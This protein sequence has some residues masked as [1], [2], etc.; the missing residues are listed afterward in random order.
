VEVLVLFGDVYPSGRG[1][2]PLTGPGISNI[3]EGPGRLLIDEVAVDLD[4]VVEPET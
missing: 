4:A 1:T 3:Y 2:W